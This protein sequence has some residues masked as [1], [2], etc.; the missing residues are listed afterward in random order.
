M[1]A[2]MSKLTSVGFIP[3]PDFPLEEHNKVHS[4]L[5]KYKDTHKLQW[6][7]FGLGWNGLAYRYR[8]AAEYD[9]EFTISIEKFGN[10]P[11]SEER[12]NQGKALFGFFVNAVSVIDCFCFSAYCMA[13]ILKPEK[14]PLSKSNELRLRTKG[15][16]SK[17]TDYFPK[18]NLTRKM[19]ECL[20]ADSYK[21]MNNIRIVL[22][23]R[24]TPPRTFYEGGERSGM[25]TMPVN[26]EAP[27]NQW[28]FDFPVDE[29]TTTLFRKW[30]SNTLEGLI[31]S[32]NNFCVSQLG[33]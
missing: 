9:N 32:A 20:S 17:F 5:N 11:P 12:Y 1:T 28:Q 2:E 6:S 8:A 31:D 25:A 21:Q 33:T 4:Y 22:I 18:D 29:Q 27:S 16:A 19:D 10:S 7:L 23:H 26:P 3:P 13:S 24:G 14:F 15:V 30:L